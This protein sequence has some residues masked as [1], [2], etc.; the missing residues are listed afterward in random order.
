MIENGMPVFPTMMGSKRKK[1]GW[2]TASINTGEIHTIAR[3]TEKGD[4]CAIT[5]RYMRSSYH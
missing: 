2:L 4:S 1:R 5:G 3:E